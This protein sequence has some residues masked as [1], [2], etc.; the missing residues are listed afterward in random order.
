MDIA[1]LT[2]AELARL[3]DQR[4]LS[5]VEVDQ[6]AARANRPAHDG[7]LHSFLRVTEEAALA[8]AAAAERELM[9]GAPARPAARHPLCAEG[10][11]R[12]R[13][14]PHH[15]PFETAP[16]SRAGAR[17]PISSAG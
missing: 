7:T 14:H 16:G 2:I 4:K 12:D 10:H 8:E 11:H 1:F 15:R 13:R 6:G 17:M 9:S 3:Y 5:P